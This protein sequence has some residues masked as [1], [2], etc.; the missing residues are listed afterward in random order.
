MASLRAQMSYPGSFLLE[1]A[2][3]FASTFIGFI[4]IWALFHRFGQV[5]GWKLYEV[6]VFYGVI[7]VTFAVAD[8]M[9][10]GFERFGREFI[11]TGDFDRVLLRP[12]AAA[13]QIL[14]HE[15]QL[16][17]LGRLA[18]GALVLAISV[19]SLDVAWGAG[20]VSLI[21]FAMAGGVALY[22]GLMALQ[23]TLAFW[24]VESLELVNIVTYGGAEAAQYPLDIYAGWFRKLLTFVVPVACV[25]Y[26]PLTVALGRWSGESAA[27]QWLA[28]LSPLA[29]FAFLALSLRAWRMGVRRYASAGG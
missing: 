18:Q 12:R 1:M 13:L 5:H 15:L 3:Q 6:G 26:Y 7:N 22:V 17:P 24:T 10:H 8:M 27:A 21:A 4:G 23:A 16:Q 2:S 29:G 25:S 19:H 20:N 14:G 28:T 11:R 9:S